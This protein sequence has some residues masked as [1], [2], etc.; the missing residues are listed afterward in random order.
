MY[1]RIRSATVLAAALLPLQLQAAQAAS[2][3]VPETASAK[4]T[5]LGVALTA[6]ELH[7]SVVVV[8]DSAA[9]VRVTPAGC[10]NAAC[11]F[12]LV[13]AGRSLGATPS[14][15]RVAT[16]DVQ[17]V[18]LNGSRAEV[19]SQPQASGA[20]MARAA[21]APSWYAFADRFCSN[22]GCA[23]WHFTLT[24]K[25][26]YDGTWAWGSRSRF[27]YAGYTNC[28]WGGAGFSVSQNECMF[29]GDPSY[30]DLYASGNFLVSAIVKGFP[31]S[32]THY[33]HRHVNGRGGYWLVA[34]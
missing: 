6:D 19:V 1:D 21:V 24:S 33:M 13:S 3:V 30:N 10:G 22:L 26:Y 2:T 5:S 9:K 18:P 27:G 34:N 4:L 8:G 25:E 16:Q 20:V 17:V 32:Q 15:A 29:Y 7:A 31:G 28:N 11:Q 14:T 12:V 23:A